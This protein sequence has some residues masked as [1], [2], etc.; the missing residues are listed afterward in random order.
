MSPYS[1]V[2]T[3][4][5]VPR[6][7]TPKAD[8][9]SDEYQRQ[10]L[11]LLAPA[12]F[13]QADCTEAPENKLGHKYSV[14]AAGQQA[15]QSDALMLSGLK[16]ATTAWEAARFEKRE[17][18]RLFRT[19]TCSSSNATLPTATP[20]PRPDCPSLSPGKCPASRLAQT[21][22]RPSV[23][24]IPRSTTAWSVFRVELQLRRDLVQNRHSFINW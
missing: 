3:C 8:R 17:R 22:T 19:T 5:V 1:S 15:A 7:L 21:R 16:G 12:V 18:G 2:A 20:S 10:I 9:L 11:Q 24:S 4:W 6:P 14:L 23:K 13:I